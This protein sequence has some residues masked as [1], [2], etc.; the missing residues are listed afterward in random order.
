MQALIVED[1]KHSSE[2]LQLLL[3]KIDEEIKVV[4]TPS[5]VAETRSWFRDNSPPDLIFMDIELGDGSAFDVLPEIS[6]NIPIVFT[7]AYDQYALKAFSYN[8]IDYLLK[9]IEK[10]K[11]SQAIEKLGQRSNYFEEGQSLNY[12]SL[13]R[14]LKV[15]F[16]KRF[17]VKLGEQYIPVDTTDILFFSNQKGACRLHTNENSYIIEHSLDQV[18]DAVNPIDFFRINRQFIVSLS[19]IREIHAYFNSRLLLRLHPSTD[20]E[21]IVSRERVPHFKRWMDL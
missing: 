6:S 4:G 13:D 10:E 20:S 11:L 8:S 17:L 9:P 3:S 12:N 5:S 16:K 14:M 7:T 2:R 15:D 1:E 18:E 21:V 19:A